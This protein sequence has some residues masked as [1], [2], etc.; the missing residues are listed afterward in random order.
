LCV[1]SEGSQVGCFLN[2]L[3]PLA[4]LRINLSS[5]SAQSS[6]LPSP[7][8]SSGFAYISVLIS[9]SAPLEQVRH[10]ITSPGVLH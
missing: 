1:P 5:T 2:S 9:L 8:A 7:L 6:P 4:T 3:W 10:F